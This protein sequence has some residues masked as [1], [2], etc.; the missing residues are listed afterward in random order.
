M[1]Y[2]LLAV[3][4]LL[5]SIPFG[6]VI[7]ARFYG[8]NIAR[9]GSG[10]IGATNVFRVLGPKAGSVVLSADILKGL[11][12]VL[13]VKLL[14]ASDVNLDL[15]E[16]LA[17][18]FV[19]LGHSASIFLGF[20]GGKGVATAAGALLA[21]MPKILL[22]LVLTWILVILITR[23]VSLASVVAAILFPVLTISFDQN[24]YHVA[25]SLAVCLTIAVKHRA[26]LVR[27]LKGTEN[28]FS[29]SKG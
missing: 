17:A 24:V 15:I 26:N 27:L 2:L 9:K 23:Y 14:A 18:G 8:V 10:N 3:A 21:M 12:A 29:V 6:M 20:S 13:I 11:L 5:G 19:V 7:G 28:K 4:Y 16:T 1:I 25:L 22:I